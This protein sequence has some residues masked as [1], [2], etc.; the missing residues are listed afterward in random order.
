ML[1]YS[2]T[3]KQLEAYSAL[4]DPVVTEI[5]FGGAAGG[6]KS[7]LAAES[8]LI[9]C[10]CIPNARVCVGRTNISDTRQSFLIT[11]TKVAEKNNFSAFNIN[12]EG[13]YFE[14]SSVISL[15]DL[16]FYPYK[17]PN[18]DRLGSKE[19][20]YAIIEEA[21]DTD[22]RAFE[23]LKLRTGR[24]LNKEYGIPGKILVT[25]NPSNNWLYSYIYERLT[26]LPPHIRYINAVAKDN[27]ELPADYVQQLDNISDDAIRRRLRDG[28]WDYWKREC[29]VVDMDMLAASFNS[30][31]QQ[32]GKRYI[33]ADIAMQGADKFVVCVWEGLTLLEIASMSKSDGKQVVDLISNLSLKYKVSLANIAYDGD[34]VGAYL[35]GYLKGAKEINNNAPPISVKLGRNTYKMQYQ[36]LRA[37]LYMTF[38]NLIKDESVNLKETPAH[39]RDRITREFSCINKIVREDGKLAISS[40]KD[41][42]ALLGGSPDF[43]D[44]LAMRAIFE[45]SP[46]RQFTRTVAA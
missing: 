26:K 17:D 35:S 45:L 3:I 33:T 43:A 31:R 42:A 30:T 28:D 37:Q 15:V 25:F 4:Y 29:T 13:I 8:A 18:F 10:S 5:F 16:S 41:I 32:R 7:W 40:K 9:M 24:H 27:P 46:A 12:R 20:T 34:G 23:V 6:G 1:A 21:G 39:L 11:F 22:K 38:A 19:Y 44:A 36:N 14:N 2:P